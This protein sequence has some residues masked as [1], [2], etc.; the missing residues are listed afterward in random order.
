MTATFATY[1][2][3]SVFVAIKSY[4][5]S[6]NYLKNFSKMQKHDFPIIFNTLSHINSDN[7]RQASKI[8]RT[9]QWYITRE[10]FEM[11][12]D[13]INSF[14]ETLK[15]ISHQINVVDAIDKATVS[16][17]KGMGSYAPAFG[18]MGTLFGLI[19]LLSEISPDNIHL[20]THGLAI[21][22]MTN[23]YGIMLSNLVFKPMAKK[24]D[25]A[26]KIKHAHAE[27]GYQFLFIIN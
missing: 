22:M 2:L 14:N 15:F 5:K 24:V 18:M 10:G 21:A 25:E 6:Y 23:L 1:S 9:L 4:L 3:D 7:K 17:L 19:Y 12:I 8:A 26:S 27:I 20:I 11:L 16:T 13:D